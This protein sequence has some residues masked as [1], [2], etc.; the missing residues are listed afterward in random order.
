MDGTM[1]GYNQSVWYI[2]TDR[3][4]WTASDISSIWGL[5]SNESILFCPQADEPNGP[6]GAT[7]DFTMSETRIYYFVNGALTEI[8]YENG[9][10]KDTQTVPTS[11]VTAATTTAP[12]VRN[13]H[14][15]DLPTGAKVGVAVG[16]T[17]GVLAT[18][19]V[20]GVLSFLRKRKRLQRQKQQQQ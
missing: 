14:A 3:N 13:T 4:L 7:T 12:A 15:P 2:G 16:V 1:D 9:N 19:G 17:L 8:R 20:S 18:A 10:W 5:Y 11:N 6:L